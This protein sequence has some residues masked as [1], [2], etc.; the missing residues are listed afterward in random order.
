LTIILSS[1]PRVGTYTHDHA[2]QF[3]RKKA[4][5]RKEKKRKK[6]KKK[7]KIQKKKKK[8]SPF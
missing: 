6:K 1:P 2:A 8:I 5:K 3:N 7:K 4:K